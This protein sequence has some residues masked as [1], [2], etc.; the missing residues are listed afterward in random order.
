MMANKVKERDF[1]AADLGDISSDSEVDD[2]EPS[3]NESSTDKSGGGFQ[4]MGLI[5]RAPSNLGKPENR[6]LDGYASE[7]ELDMRRL[8]AEQNKKK[9][10]SGGFQ[11]MGLG[12]AVFRGVMKKGYKVPTPIQRKVSSF[13]RRISHSSFLQ[14]LNRMEPCTIV[15]CL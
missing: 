10:K 6:D 1:T 8:V 14:Q 2:A 12:Q 13:S 4:S 3:D 15:Y 7:N 5:L 9:K 11:S